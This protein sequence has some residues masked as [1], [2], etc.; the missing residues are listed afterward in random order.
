MSAISFIFHTYE[1]KGGIWLVLEKLSKYIALKIKQSDPEGPT[2]VEIMEYELGVRLNLIAT[3]LLTVIFALFTGRLTESLIALIGF[4]V[5]RRFSGGWHMRSLTTCAFVSSV[6]FTLIPFIMLNKSITLIITLLSILL[7][8]I[9][10][11]NDF[12]EVNPSKLDPYLKVISVLIVSSNLFIM[13]DVLG[14]AFFAQ[15][16]LLISWGEVISWVKG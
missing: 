11:P 15:A 10:A 9:L 14:L 6:L 5:S 1:S 8:A 4:A 16:M 3:I 2:S 12:I 13:S 7:F